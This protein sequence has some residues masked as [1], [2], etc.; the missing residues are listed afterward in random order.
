LGLTNHGQIIA[1]AAKD[2]IADLANGD[3]ASAVA[4]LQHLS[5][6]GGQ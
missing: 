3:N 4:I 6:W 5:N 1:N 2:A